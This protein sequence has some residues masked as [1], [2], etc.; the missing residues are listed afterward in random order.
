MYV[1][2]KIALDYEM[3]KVAIGSVFRT[4]LLIG[5]IFFLTT[6]VRILE[7]VFDHWPFMRIFLAIRLVKDDIPYN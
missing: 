3:R 4:V 1:W 2:G 5:F 7:F 6:L